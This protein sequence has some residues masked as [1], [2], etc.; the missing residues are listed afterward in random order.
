MEILSK[1]EAKAKRKNN[2]QFACEA[3]VLKIITV[4]VSVTAIIISQLKG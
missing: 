1:E 2:E 4:I 3:I